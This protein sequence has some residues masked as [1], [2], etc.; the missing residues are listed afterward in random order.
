MS[1]LAPIPQEKIEESHIWREW[2]KNIRLMV[3]FDRTLTAT[4]TNGAQTINK[5]AG[6][7]NF[8]IGATSLV[9]T[10][11][12]VD[13]N[14]VVLCSLGTNDSTMKSVSVVVA[15]GSFTI[16]ANAAATAATRVNF[17]VIN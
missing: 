3:L 4:G 12:Q 16:Y 6:S 9:V 5:L 2:F 14:S 13:S 11:N 7:V 8:A 17:V 1:H 15:T 10:N